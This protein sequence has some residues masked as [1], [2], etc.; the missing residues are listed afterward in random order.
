MALA[1]IKTTRPPAPTVT[2]R[3]VKNSRRR[4]T[5]R[6]TRFCAASSDRAERWADFAQGFVLEVAEKTAA[7]SVSS[8]ACHGLVKQRFDERPVRSSLAFMA[9]I[10]VAFVRA[11]AGGIRAR[12]TSIAVRHATLIKPGGQNGIS[13]EFG[14]IAG[15]IGK[16]R[17]GNLLCQRSA[18]GPGAMP[19]N[20][21]DSDDG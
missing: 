1:E 14:G 6:V 13:A 9:F 20:T 21:P 18:N 4:S 11:T 3:F 12:T 19:P 16:D 5:A 7:R 10:S 8:S 15:Q 2:F 17:L